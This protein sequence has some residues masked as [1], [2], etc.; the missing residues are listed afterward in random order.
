MQSS[1]D[2]GAHQSTRPE[3]PASL[4]DPAAQEP[5]TMCNASMKDPHPSPQPSPPPLC[6]AP[7]SRPPR[8]PSVRGG[9][10]SSSRGQA[11]RPPPRSGGMTAW[12]PVGS[13]RVCL[14]VP[15]ARPVA[16][17]LPGAGCLVPCR[18]AVGLASSSRGQARAAFRL[19]RAD[20]LMPNRSGG[21]AS[22]FPRRSLPPFRSGGPTAWCPVGPRRVCLPVPAAKAAALPLR[23]GQPAVW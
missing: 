14:P 15:A 23:S 1:A 20:C 2:A 5:L 22:Q 17:R 13:R 3:Q 7:V 9:S 19:R 16:L 11:R 18:F 8:H 12:C 10:A 4:C 21:S 6:P